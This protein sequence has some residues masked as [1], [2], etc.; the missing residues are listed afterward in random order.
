MVRLHSHVPWLVLIAALA[1]Q[2][3]S[4]RPV[5]ADI[6]CEG[7]YGGHLQGL[8]ADAQ[9]IYWS[10]TVALVKTDWNGKVLKSVPVP[11]HHGDLTCH[12][13]KLYCAVNLGA[14]NKEP[15]LAD[16]WVYVFDA[17][18]LSLVA[19][20]KVPEVVH[21]AGGMDY[22]R[23]HYFLVGGLPAGRQENY[24][25]EYDEQFRFLKRHVIPSGYTLLGIQTTCHAYGSW[26]FG[27]YGKKVLQTDDS[28]RLL[29]K[30]DLDYAVGIAERP[31]EKL[32]RAVTFKEGGRW[33][34]KASIIP[35]PAPIAHTPAPPAESRT[36]TAGAAG[37]PE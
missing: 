35:L 36:G 12:E 15:G 32:L 27:C 16:S 29:A 13:G 31:E 22:Y 26:W 11:S 5:G 28:F 23:G 4:G 37:R 14:F 10:F 8:A 7:A 18:D 33:R 20:H 30:Y 9:A 1:I 19:K 6:V 3:F 34:A 17:S 21:G 24:V 2:G 25:Y